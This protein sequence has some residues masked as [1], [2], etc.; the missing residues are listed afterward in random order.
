MMCQ[1]KIV[2][3]IRGNREATE[4]LLKSLTPESATYLNS[5]TLA[6]FKRPK[7][8][9]MGSNLLEAAQQIQEADK[10]KVLE[11]HSWFSSFCKFTQSNTHNC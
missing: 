10:Y 9:K 2:T 1:S 6:S 5:R 11:A 4:K 8:E 3:N 7:E